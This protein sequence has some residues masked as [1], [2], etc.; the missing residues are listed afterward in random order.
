MRHREYRV[1]SP[2]MSI[3]APLYFPTCHEEFF[4]RASMSITGSAWTRV[5]ARVLRKSSIICR[6]SG[7]IDFISDIRLFISG[8]NEVLSD[9][10]ASYALAPDASVVPRSWK[11]M[12]EWMNT[13][14]YQSHSV[15]NRKTLTVT[16]TE[17][18]MREDRVYRIT[19]TA[20]RNERGLAKLEPRICRNIS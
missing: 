17:E 12:I 2:W 11:V 4:I 1:P 9:K 19:R 7:S 3:T 5:T 16:R 20:I 13:T 18:G 10:S 14:W 6:I 8:S 15:P